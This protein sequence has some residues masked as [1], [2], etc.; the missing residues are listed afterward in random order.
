MD[1]TDLTKCRHDIQA[2]RATKPDGYR[3]IFECIK[4]NSVFYGQ[5]YTTN[6]QEKSTINFLN[7]KEDAK[8]RW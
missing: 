8:N 3:T 4:C 5:E 1:A 2:Q 7:N 6:E